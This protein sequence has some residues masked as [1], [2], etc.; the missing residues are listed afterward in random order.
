MKANKEFL[1]N[2]V[3][4][5]KKMRDPIINAMEMYRRD[6]KKAGDTS[7]DES[8][9]FSDEDMGSDDPFKE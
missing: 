9:E 2:V 6:K 1:V 7:S 8:H 5:M 3:D 4:T